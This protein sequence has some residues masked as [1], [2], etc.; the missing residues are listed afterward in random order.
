MQGSTCPA[1]HTGLEIWNPSR[2]SMEVEVRGRRLREAEGEEKKSLGFGLLQ[3]EARNRLSVSSRT[4]EGLSQWPSVEI[5]DW[6]I[7]QQDWVWNVC[8]EKSSIVF[9]PWMSALPHLYLCTWNIGNVVLQWQTL[10]VTRSL[11]LYSIQILQKTR[12]A[13]GSTLDENAWAVCLSFWLKYTNCA[14]EEEG[15]RLQLW[16]REDDLNNWSS[17]H[18]QSQGSLFIMTNTRR[19]GR[20]AL[21]CVGFYLITPVQKRRVKNI[22]GLFR[23]WKI[24]KKIRLLLLWIQVGPELLP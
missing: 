12:G 5:T 4:I 2:H 10:P 16:K 15:L 6:L 18:R 17:S 11:L 22:W 19:S 13:F 23:S 7:C 8:V 14:V 24:Y 21:F 20:A 3:Q 1:C 9:C